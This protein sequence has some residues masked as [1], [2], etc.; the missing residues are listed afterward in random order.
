MTYDSGTNI[1]MSVAD[2]LQFLGSDRAAGTEVH[3]NQTADIMARTVRALLNIACR[4]WRF[5]STSWNEFS[6]DCLVIFFFCA[7]YYE[8]TLNHVA[9][10]LQA[11][12]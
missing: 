4:C 1:N 9:I 10:T 7:F 12:A 6:Y 5:P 8:I 3:I 11:I 2:N